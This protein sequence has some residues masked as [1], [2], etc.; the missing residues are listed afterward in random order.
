M[1]DA[2]ERD[3][4]PHN[5]R[6]HGFNDISDHIPLTEL[7]ITGSVYPTTGFGLALFLSIAFCSSKDVAEKFE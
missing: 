7:V 5:S 1:G 3:R 4:A 6:E 2:G